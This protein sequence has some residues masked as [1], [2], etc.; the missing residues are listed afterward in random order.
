MFKDFL[1]EIFSNKCQLISLRLNVPIV[2]FTNMNF[3]QCLSLSSNVYSSSI[4]NQNSCYYITLRYLH[5]RISYACFLEH[6]I[7]HVPN[8][9]C[10]SVCLRRGWGRNDP[11]ESTFGTLEKSNVIWSNKVKKLSL[12]YSND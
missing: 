7:E 9:K 6:L 10:L 4:S 8:L 5:I 11:L 1:R 12:S 2:N 3:H